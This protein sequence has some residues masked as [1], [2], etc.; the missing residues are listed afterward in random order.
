MGKNKD[1]E[2]NNYKKALSKADTEFA[3]ES[4]LKKIA[5]R[6]QKNENK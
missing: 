4:G 6:A 1:N 2:I 5:I 3:R